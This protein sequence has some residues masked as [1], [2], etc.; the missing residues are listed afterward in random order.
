MESSQKNWDQVLS[1]VIFAYNTCKQDTTKKSPFELVYGYEPNLPIDICL[2]TTDNYVR[3][4]ADYL[5][6]MR[7][8]AVQN[9]KSAFSRNKTHYDKHR[10]DV[11][12]KIGD[13][14]LLKT[15]KRKKG[16]SEKLMV[17]Y[18][19]PYV[20]QEQLSPVN[21][22]IEN[23]R[24]TGRLRLKNDVVHI[25]RLKKYVPR[26]NSHE[27]ENRIPTEDGDEDEHGDSNNAIANNEESV[28]VQVDHDVTFNIERGDLENLFET[29]DP[30]SVGNDL[31]T[32]EGESATP[33]PVRT[34]PEIIKRS[35]TFADPLY[36][37]IGD[38]LPRKSN[39]KLSGTKKPDYYYY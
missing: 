1:Y 6:M 28:R 22:R 2:E 19:G 29:E 39:R 24:Q 17:N 16:L 3:K 12:F 23:V 31:P 27:K 37:I 8:E 21:F 15:P 5:E 30:S 33:F 18:A 25:N 20:I 32:V 4:H 34:A 38:N 14:V 10:K 36:R 26:D 9:I 35:V 11:Q 7:T 13:Y